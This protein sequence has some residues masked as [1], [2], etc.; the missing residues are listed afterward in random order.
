MKKYGK[1]ERMPDGTRAKQPPVKSVLLQTYFTSLVCLLMCVTMFFGTTFAWF[2]S[3]V[4][5]EGNEIY[6]GTLDVDLQNENGES[7]AGSDKKLFDGTTIHWEP[8]YTALRKLTVQNKG[9]LAFNYE[10]MLTSGK[11][12]DK[13]GADAL[14]Q[15]VA[16]HFVV[17]VHA[18]DYAE[19]ETEPKSFADDIKN[20]DQWAPVMKGNA[21][22]TLADILDPA[23]DITIAKGDITATT[24]DSSD[25]YIIALHMNEDTSSDVMGYRISM[26]VKLV[27]Y[28]MGYEKDD[29]D[30]SY[31][32][33]AKATWVTNE[34]EL[35]KALAKGETPLF[36][37]D[38]Q[39]TKPLDICDNTTI[40]GGGYK[41]TRAEG[42]TGTLIGVKADATLTLKSIVLDGGANWTGEEDPVL[43]RGTVNSG[44]T[45]TGN[46]IATEG[47]GSIVLEGGT[48]LQNNVGAHAVSLATRGGG[49][50]TLNGAQ[51]INNSSDSG[52]IWGGGNIIVNEGSKINCNSS[53]GIAGAVRMVGS[54]N[55]TMNGGEISYNKADSDGGA[56]WGYGSSTY[57]FNGGEMSGN[58][59]VGTGGAFY[60]GNYSVINI[61]DDFEM[62]DNKAADSGAIRLTDHTSLTMTGGLISGNTQSG[63]SNA[64]NTWNNSISI[65]GG[66][67]SDNFSFVGGLGLNIGAADIDGVIAYDLSTNHNT[68]YL[69]ADFKG[70]KFTVNE[71]DEHFGNF[72]FK[73]AAGYVYAE[74]DEAKLICMNAGYKTVW[75]A[76]SGTFKLQAE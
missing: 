68:A 37:N 43:D 47:N 65:T 24:E 51:I 12:Q 22:A 39:L 49:S 26:D 74:D 17:Y 45:A 21:V 53:T 60:T 46:L 6:I 28:Q 75:D 29:F 10:L 69:A 33:N 73:P 18:G 3:E 57:N 32:Q 7:L 30:G 71:S 59:S 5:N 19:G 11:A 13:S 1:Y 61:S 25:T 44:V 38:I 72:N 76:T 70:F 62:C 56:I 55:L 9:D 36:G 27:A 23:N 58:E 54:C 67:I 15:T 20:S 50:L 48:V 63:E 4:T 8:G 64:F 2:T 34:D 14:L 41:L 35:S 16:K 66:S 52:A 42:F 31:D 40:I